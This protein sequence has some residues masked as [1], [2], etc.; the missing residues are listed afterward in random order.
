MRSSHIQI[1]CEL[2]AIP[3]TSLHDAMTLPKYRQ[4]DT[5]EAPLEERIQKALW[6]YRRCFGTKQEVSIR[7]ASKLYGI[8][9]SGWFE[10]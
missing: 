1:D 2:E 10:V 9:W 6:H 5:E 4:I 8:D 3:T 7:K